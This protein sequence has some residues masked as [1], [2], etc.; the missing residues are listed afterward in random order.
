MEKRAEESPQRTAMR[1]FALWWGALGAFTFL[2][3]ARD[4]AAVL[5]RLPLPLL[6]ALTYLGI[7]PFTLALWG[8][9]YY[10][11]YILVGRRML[12]VP[13]IVLYVLVYVFFVYATAAL[14]PA[15]VLVRTWDV[16][17]TFAHVIP[18]AL[19]FAILA[20]LVVPILAAVLAYGTLLFRVKRREQRLRIALVSFAFFAWFGG[21][22]LVALA[23]QGSREWW[24]LASR[25]LSLASVVLVF[26]AYA[27]P[28]RA[29]RGPPGLPGARRPAQSGPGGRQGG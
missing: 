6:V 11:G 12:L 3:F 27:L 10:L 20:L 29:G 22:F 17:V 7:A 21:T 24:A 18:P 15:G 8:L 16:E 1:A 14:Q 4:L 28:W 5:D 25:V 23:G 13:S 2:G 26:L 9:F 19:D